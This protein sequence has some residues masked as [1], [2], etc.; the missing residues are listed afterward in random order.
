[1]KKVVLMLCILLMVSSLFGCVN[2]TVGLQTDST[3]NES[4][5]IKDDDHHQDSLSIYSETIND[6]KKLIEFRLSET[7]E[8]DYNDGTFIELNSNLKADL[9][10]GS[11]NSDDASLTLDYK[12][13]NMIVDMLD[14]INDKSLDSFGYILKDLDDNGSHEL[15]WVSTDYNVIFAI[16]TIKNNTPHLLDAYWS[17]YKAVILD[18]GELYTLSSGGA[19][20]ICYTITKLDENEVNG[21]KV[22][23]QFGKSKDK[24]YFELVEDNLITINEERFSNLL[25]DNPFEFGDSWHDNKLYKLK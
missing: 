16:F 6:Y 13:N 2:S 19:D 21:M 22:S 3:K 4:S 11:N 8:E 9:N 10:Q 23:R 7:F 12:W 17:R 24:E 25:S 15:L 1:M 5:S 18:S 20:T 14:Y